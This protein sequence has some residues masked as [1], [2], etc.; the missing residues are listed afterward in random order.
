M[1]R[2]HRCGSLIAG[3]IGVFLLADNAIACKAE[4][5]KTTGIS[6]DDHQGLALMDPKMK[7]T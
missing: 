2:A 3:L 6:G 7:P 5:M 4:K 1:V